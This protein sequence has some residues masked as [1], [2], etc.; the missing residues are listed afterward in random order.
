MSLLHLHCASAGDIDLKVLSFQAPLNGIMQQA[1]TRDLMQYFPIKA[2]QPTFQIDVICSN[3][4]E[5]MRLQSFV[6]AHQKGALTSDSPEVYL[7]WSERNINGWSGI[8]QSMI[9]GDER[10]NFVPRVTLKFVLI[11][12][13]LSQK[14]WTSSFASDFSA[15]FF[16]LQTPAVAPEGFNAPT[17]YTRADG[18]APGSNGGAALPAVGSSYPSN[19]ALPTN[20]RVTK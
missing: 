5:Y 1:Q 18:I 17:V 7:D 20:P 15:L 16:N 14:T 11:T 6:R 8:I 10:W 19:F 12:S 4:D 3:T 9:A 2:E 13:L